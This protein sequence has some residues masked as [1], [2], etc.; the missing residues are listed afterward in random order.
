[1][2]AFLFSPYLDEGTVLQLILQQA[3]FNVRS[4][5]R[6]EQAIETWPENPADLV[7]IA[8]NDNA[9]QAYKPIRQIRAHTV[10][11]IIVI[12]DHLSDEVHINFLDA[13]ADLVVGRP[14]SIRPLIAQIRALLRRN[15]GLPFF[16]LPTLS[17]RDLIL[18]PSDRTVRVGRR[19]SRRLTHLEFRLLYTLM[20]HT[21]QYIQPEQIVEHVWGYCGDGNRELV[22]GLIQRLRS[23]VE[24]D[25]RNPVYILTEPGIGYR[26]QG[27]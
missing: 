17:Q 1:M 24:P 13:G 9:P 10:I 22:R 11:P 6:L 25:P 20:T 8:L 12:V 5:L 16:A 4:G 14:F 15:S 2:Q 19:E 26:F 3:G 27:A 18:D 23:K 21:G 7:M